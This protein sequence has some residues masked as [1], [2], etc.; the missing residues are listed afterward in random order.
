MGFG[1]YSRTVIFQAFLLAATTALFFW[2]LHLE[3]A[4]ITL[5]NVALLWI[6]QLVFLVYTLQKVNRDIARFLE[7]LANQDAS[8]SYNPQKADPG[9]LHLY[10]QMNRILSR[11]REEKSQWEKEYQFFQAIFEH[12]DTGLVTYDDLGNIHLCN[13]AALNLLGSSSASHI[14]A[15]RSLSPGLYDYMKNAIPGRREL[16]QIK[17]LPGSSVWLSVRSAAIVLPGKR[18]TLL[19]M[20]NIRQE[21]EESETDSWQKL[22]RVLVHEITNSV[23]P[24]NITATGMIQILEKVGNASRI[25]D[26]MLESMHAGLLAIRNR[27]RGMASFVDAF[28]KL[29]RIPPPECST[30]RMDDLVSSILRLMQDSFSSAGI[31][32]S[33]RCIPSDLTLYADRQQVE[34]VLMNLLLNA[35]EALA[36]IADPQIAVAAIEWLDEILL[37][38]SDNGMGI[39]PENLENI[40]VPFFSTRENGSGIGLSLSRQIM[41]SHKGRIEVQSSPGKTVFTLHFRKEEGKAEVML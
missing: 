29:T 37:S 26:E 20:Q 38:V 19:S 14:Q 33:V 5:L 39:P 24:I 16:I 11:Q 21:L 22:I 13:K 41:K 25:D 12:A 8:F 18:Y 30:F 35:K 1:R 9:M 3:F 36:G 32:T 2:L 40:F 34:Q 4:R 27:S 10:S 7:T 17:G 6:A 15:W 23:S 31:R 28:R